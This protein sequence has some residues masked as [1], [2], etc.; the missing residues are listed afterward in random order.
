M[1]CIQLIEVYYYK[2][3]EVMHY[4]TPPSLQIDSGDF[5]P[6][7]TPSRDEDS[8][9]RRMSRSRSPSTASDMEPIEVIWRI[10]PSYCCDLWRYWM[11]L[12]FFGFLLLQLVDHSSRLH[13]PTS[14]SSQEHPSNKVSTWITHTLDNR[15]LIFS[16]SDVTVMCRGACNLNSNALH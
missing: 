9:S 8:K 6:Y 11:T 4:S 1:H 3:N 14:R 5:T 16:V 12:T 13:T 10:L 7:N 15:G 2:Q